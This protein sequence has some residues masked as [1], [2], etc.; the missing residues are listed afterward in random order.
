MYRR[1]SNPIV[2]SS[3]HFSSTQLTKIKYQANRDSPLEIWYQIAVYFN[4]RRTRFGI[5]LSKEEFLALCYRIDFLVEGIFKKNNRVV[6]LERQR[7]NFKWIVSVGV[8]LENGLETGNYINLTQEDEQS[9]LNYMD[10]CI[11]G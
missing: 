7:T 8:E 9:L 4:G 5:V 10:K 6:S 2:L 11:R 1:M 3:N